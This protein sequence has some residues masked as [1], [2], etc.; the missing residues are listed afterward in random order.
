LGGKIALR[1]VIVLLIIST[2]KAMLCLVF[3]IG[4]TLNEVI[5]V[6][7]DLQERESK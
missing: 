2:A 5:I 4:K 3:E 7:D 6:R 1:F